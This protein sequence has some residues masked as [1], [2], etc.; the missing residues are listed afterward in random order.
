MVFILENGFSG[1]C[2]VII[3]PFDGMDPSPFDDMEPPSDDIEPHLMT[4]ISYDMYAFGDVYL[5]NFNIWT[6]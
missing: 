4:S 2:L 5:P 3:L 1:K 6:P